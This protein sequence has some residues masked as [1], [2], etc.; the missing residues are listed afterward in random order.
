MRVI[1]S[2][3]AVKKQAK[4]F[5]RTF[6]DK[7]RNAEFFN[8][9]CSGFEVRFRGTFLKAELLSVSEREPMVPEE[10]YEHP[11]IAV[12]TD[13]N[14]EPVR[15]ELTEPRRWYTL[16]Q[17][18]TEAEHT[19]RVVKL[20]EDS[21]GKT[22]LAAVETDG[23]LEPLFP[24]EPAFRLEFVG[25][26][27]TCGFGDEAPGRDAPFLTKEENGLAAYPALTAKKLGAEFSCVCF[28][29]I[30][31]GG[32][33]PAGSPLPPMPGMEDLYA[34]TDRVYESSR[35]KKDG[36]EPWDFAAHPV[37]AVCINLGTNDV[38]AIKMAQA[39]VKETEERNFHDRY[40]KFLRSIRRLNGPEPWICCT[41]GPL[42]YYLYD[43][44]RD[45]VA[46]YRAESGDAKT[47][48]FKFGGVDMFREGFGAIGH[49]SVKTHA[50]MAEELVRKLLPLLKQK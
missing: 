38:N 43:I 10:V 36:F 7:E 48:S 39:Q 46:D 37:D 23:G 28:S 50:R 30:S 45:A 6:S 25:D 4:F 44:I 13:G 27:I 29:G 42:D 19:V 12:F 41:L 31:V 16:F 8:W 3:D 47:V 49:P 26:S 40:V 14:P 20:S 2:I 17:G 34:Y 24:A 35:G 18:E 9:T 22:G 33:A 11:W 15:M 5:G 21:R 1:V 32:F